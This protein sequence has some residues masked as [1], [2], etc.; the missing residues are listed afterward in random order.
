MPRSNTQPQQGEAYGAWSGMVRP[1]DLVFDIG[2]NVGAKT[3][4]LLAMGARVVCV[5]PQP[6]CVAEL[7]RQFPDPAR[8]TIVPQGVAGEPGELDLA[9]CREASTLATFSSAWKQGRFA[10]CHWDKSVRVPMTTLDRL[11]AEHGRPRYC[12]IDVEG[13]ELEVLQGL[14]EPLDFLSFEYAR[15]FHGRAAECLARLRA[16]GYQRFNFSEGESTALAFWHWCG[17]DELLAKLTQPPAADL[18]GD[19]YAAYGFAAPDDLARLRE[20]G[21]AAAGQDVRL[22]LGCGERR[23]P[24]Y[25]NV[26]FP[27]ADHTVQKKCVADVQANIAG[28]C[29]PAG[30]V[31]EIRSHHVFEHFEFPAALALLS[32]WHDWLQ[33]GGRLVIE[34]PDFAAA[35]QRYLDPASPPDRQAVVLRHVFGSHEAAWAVHRDAWDE[36]KFNRVLGALGW[37]SLQFEKATWHATDNITVRAT[38]PAGVARPELAGRSAALLR[39]ALVDD[40]ASEQE[41]WMVWMGRYRELVAGLWHLPPPRVSIYMPMYNRERYLGATVD[42]LLNQTFTAFELILADDGSTDRTLDL[43]REYARYDARLHVLSLPHAGEVAARNRAVRAAHPA[44]EYLMNHDSDDVS[45]PMKLARLVAY[46][47]SHPD[48]A[49]VGCFAEYF[50][51]AGACLGQPKLEHQ[52]A[53]IRASFGRVNSMVNSATLV[54]RAVFDRVGLF[55]EEF[56]GADD[57]DFYARLLR[58]GYELANLPFVLHRIRLH[59]QSV[60][61]ARAAEQHR[62]AERIGRE[63]EQALARPASPGPDPEAKP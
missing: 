27:P 38:K 7:R 34:T 24:G 40:S 28:L 11:V 55:R 17:A 43:A 9:L 4:V 61:S 8:V 54:R 30:S 56:R 18:W 25:I 23:L 1:G 44:A 57:Y 16:L 48:V 13:F 33:P 41:L 37:D 51:D 29:F 42:S 62:L 32:A 63:Y 14:T 52:P 60:G 12:K 45:Q 59:P 36:A 5:E 2:A 31:A 53:R 58:A 22:H 10:T 26:D 50:N 47:D 39:E 15:E 21:L 46:L 19:I 49:G 20:R 6:D 3:R 35:A